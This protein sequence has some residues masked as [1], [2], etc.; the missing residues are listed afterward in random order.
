MLEEFV[1]NG[2]SYHDTDSIKLADEL[3]SYKIKE[4]DQEYVMPYIKLASHTMGEHLKEWQRLSKLLD[5]VL[6]LDFVNHYQAYIYSAVAA[7]ISGDYVNASVKEAQA[8]ARTD[9]A[10]EQ[11][12][13]EYRLLLASSL[14]SAGYEG[15]AL[16]I[17]QP[18]MQLCKKRNLEEKLNRF[19]AIINNNLASQLLELDVLNEEQKS[20]LDLS[21]KAA[22]VYWK[23]CGT[24]V[25]EERGLYL[26]VLI[27]NKLEN[28]SKAVEFGESALD[29][30]LKNGDEPVDE[31]FIKLAMANSYKLMSN[32]GA[33]QKYIEMADEM[34][35]VWVDDSLKGWYEVERQKVV[36]NH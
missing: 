13:I 7:Y 11:A 8:M 27:N 2:W 4:A 14:S 19:I 23:K 15:A 9:V 18:T 28:Y 3:E 20:L 36:A 34:S 25:H 26:L 24:W 12:Y 6:A 32:H 30:I 10:L 17:Y 5:Q 33:F 16:C 31:A 1:K 29:V 22:L 35:S 21:S